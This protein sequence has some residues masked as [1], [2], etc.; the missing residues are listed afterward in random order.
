VHKKHL[1]TSFS[2]GPGVINTSSDHADLATSAI[3]CNA[4]RFS[5]AFALSDRWSL[6]V[7]YDRIGSDQGYGTL[8]KFHMENYVLE[9]S[10][11]PWIRERAALECTVGLG[12]SSSALFPIDTRLPYT[13][14]GGVFTL[15]ARYL[16]FFNKTIGGMA[17]LEHAASGTEELLVEGGT[18]NPDGSTSTLQWSSQRFTLGIV[19]KF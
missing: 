14:S 9:G 15:G 5:F 13:S 10:Y 6:G 12:A 1:L 7:H 4:F 19:V 8:D 11:R 16:H 17:S 3:A 18:V 2:G